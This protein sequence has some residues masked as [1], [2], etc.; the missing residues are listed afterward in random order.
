MFQTLFMQTD[1][2]GDL[3][4]VGNPLP[5]EWAKTEAEA[6]L[7]AADRARINEKPLLLETSSMQALAQFDADG[8]LVWSS[9]CAS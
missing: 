2:F 3:E 9:S 4:P 5:L 6:L 1:P 7:H 8:S